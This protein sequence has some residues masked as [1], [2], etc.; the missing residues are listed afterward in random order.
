MKEDIN[1]CV[2]SFTEVAKSLIGSRKTT[3]PMNELRDLI[4]AATL[5][6]STTRKALRWP[7]WFGLMQLRFLKRDE[8]HGVITY[9]GGGTLLVDDQTS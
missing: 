5:I 1:Q 2:E 6:Y 3:T 7:R 9:A 8:A 4:K